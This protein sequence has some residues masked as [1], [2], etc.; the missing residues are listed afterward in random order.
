MKVSGFTIIRNAIT[1]DFPV[2]E[3]ILSILPLCDEVIVSVGNSND[4]TLELIKSIQSPKIKIIESSWDESI[5]KGG[6]LLAKETNKAFD[7]VSADS[8][9]V[10]YIQA[11]EV[12]HEK[13]IPV[14]KDSM[15]KWKDH[16]E[17]EGLLFE[18]LHFYGSYAF[19]EDSKLW[20]RNEIRIVRNDK[21]IRS[22]R[23]AQGFRIYDKLTP[24]DEELLHGGRKLKVKNSGAFM[25]HYG[26]AKNPI[27]QQ[28]K[29]NTFN[30]LWSEKNP[31]ENKSAG[32]D[33]SQVC[34]LKRFEGSHP[35]VMQERVKKQDWNF[36]FDTRKKNLTLRESI[37]RFLIIN[38]GWRP[39]EYKNYKLM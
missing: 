28:T 35:S 17:V 2:V 22:Y 31:E 1:Y 19:L 5:R 32:F 30:K 11:D 33:Y 21:H 10:I 15:Q 4:T 26:W 29:R 38:T 36:D 23:D 14:L 20:Y 39:G 8:D 3:S 27:V 37:N 18:Y 9:W 24:T 12:I 13:D 6:L 7:A 16:K 34:A 25:Y